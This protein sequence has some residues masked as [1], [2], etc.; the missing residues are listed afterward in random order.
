MSAVAVTE[1]ERED[2]H[3]AT[4]GTVSLVRR[5]AGSARGTALWGW[6][7]PLLVT[8]FAACLRFYRL[9]VP[10]AVV[11]DETY[12]A[13]DA[14]GVLRFGASQETVE[15]A[16]DQL[17]A[18]NSHIFTGS[19]NF[20]VHPQ[21]GKTLIAA[22]EWLFGANPFGWR[23]A[24]AVVGSLAVLILARTARRMTG[25]TL[26]GCVAGLLLA[27]DGLEFTHSRLALLDIFVMFWI[28]AG[29]ACLVADRDSARARLARRVAPVGGGALGPWLGVR[30]WRLA[31]GV[32]L[33]LA[34]A[35]KWNA[36]PFV[37][38]FGLLAFFWDIAARRRARVRRPFLGALALDAAP[39]FVSIVVLAL[40]A[41]IATWMPWFLSDAGWGRHWAAEH[42][43]GGPLIGLWHYHREMWHFHTNLSTPHDYQSWPWTWILL[44]RPVAYYYTSPDTCGASDCSSAIHGLG[45]PAIWW[46]SMPA[47]LVMVFLLLARRDWRAGGIIMAV[48]AGWLPWF[49]SAIRD[50]TE[51]L[52]YALPMLPFLV[53]AVTM[54]LGLVLGRARASGFRRGLG[55]AL[56]GAY[57]LI[58]IANFYYLYPIL[59]AEVIPYHAWHARMW[60]HSWI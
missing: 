49:F 39:A 25:S 1:A 10:H 4:R 51:F 34:C 7:G 29:F 47:L 6:L 54:C 27:L 8:A 23:F 18:G 2:E 32:C 19:P 59:S 38:G 31:A 44:L 26:L 52:F 37:A 55:A 21:F 57:L 16:N 35:S 28:V 42:G 43:A 50:R 48:A 15:N 36:V 46:F 11:F 14:L 33:G 13:K 24:A 17:L 45:T 30:P 58:V 12:Y 20:V 5:Y 40:F 56:V 53:L 22:G 60:L 3:E 41:Y 9:G